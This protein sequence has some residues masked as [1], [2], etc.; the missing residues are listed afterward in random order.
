MERLGF[1]EFEINSPM[2]DWTS[3]TPFKLSYDKILGILYPI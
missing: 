2:S 1:I 3:L